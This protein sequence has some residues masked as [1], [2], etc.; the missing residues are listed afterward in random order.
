MK[1]SLAAAVSSA[2]CVRACSSS[3]PS[4]IVS[5]MYGASWSL[6]PYA[7]RI[8]TM[9]SLASGLTTSTDLSE[10]RASTHFSTWSGRHLTMSA[11]TMYVSAVTWSMF[12]SRKLRS[13]STR[14]SAVCPKFIAMVP[15]A[16]M[17]SREMVSFGSVAYSQSSFTMS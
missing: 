15:T 17:D 1:N 4:T 9:A 7:P 13:L 16:L 10:A 11:I 6:S 5:R 8:H 2:S 3:K 14:P 12:M